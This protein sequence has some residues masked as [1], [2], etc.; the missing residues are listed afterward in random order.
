MNPAN[1]TAF[2]EA[3]IRRMESDGITA[4]GLARD[5]GVTKTQIDKLRQRRAAATNV[6]DAMR[7]ARTF[8]MSVEDFIHREG[9]DETAAIQALVNRL[10]SDAQ[11][12]VR[13]QLEGLVA[14]GM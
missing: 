5:S 1:K 12:F 10:S 7:I 4:A 11:A 6:H 9:V 13:A 3:L 14:R 8:G 2:R